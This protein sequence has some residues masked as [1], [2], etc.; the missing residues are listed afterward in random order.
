MR[1]SLEEA[2]MDDELHRETIRQQP[3]MAEPQQP[4]DLIEQA[5]ATALERVKRWYR[6]NP[7]FLVDPEKAAQL[8]YC[9]FVACREVGEEGTDAYYQRM[10][11]FSVCDS[12]R[13]ATERNSRRPHLQH[14]AILRLCSD[15]Q[16][17]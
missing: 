13:M 8:N 5:I 12:N 11:T 1:A 14:L 3:R 9:H 4:V 7:Q 16:L 15:R 6:A 10:E 17:P 2:D